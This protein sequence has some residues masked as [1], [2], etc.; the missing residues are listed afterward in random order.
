MLKGKMTEE[1]LKAKYKKYPCPENVGTLKPTR[2]NQLVWDKIRPAT[3]S[4]DLKLQRVQQLIMKGIIALG[5]GAHLVLN[6]PGLDK[7]VVHEFFDAVAFM[8]QGS[9][10]LN[11]TRRELIKPDL[12]RDFQ[13]LCSNAVP[14]SSELFGDDITKYVKDITESSKMSWKIVRG[15]SDNRYRPYRGRP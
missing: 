13:N 3:R 6:F 14:I 2:V 4:R 5:K 12:S 1:K 9:M 11:L 8:A 10:E 15:G 7:G